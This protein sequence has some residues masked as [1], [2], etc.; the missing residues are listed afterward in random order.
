MADK[1]LPP[2]KGFSHKFTEVQKTVAA[3]VALIGLGV[4]ISNILIGNAASS[5]H[6][7]VSELEPR[8][9]TLEVKGA[10]AEGRWERVEEQLYEVRMDIRRQRANRPLPP[11]PTPHPTETPKVDQ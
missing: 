5:A 11:V 2:L 8:V 4:I 1:K 6:K 7:K 3:I 9:R 10:K